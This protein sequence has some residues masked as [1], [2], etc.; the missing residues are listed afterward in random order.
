MSV[1]NQILDGTPAY[2]SVNLTINSVVYA[3]NTF[4]CT[5]DTKEAE[6]ETI[7]GYPQ[8]R[9]VVRGRYKITA[10]VQLATN[11]TTYPKFGDTFT[12]TP[13]NDSSITF[14]IDSTEQPLTNDA[15]SFN[16]IPITA[17]GAI[18]DVTTS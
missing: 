13:K 18:G 5:T 10:E 12:F 3:C 6:D 11:S 4:N 7:L 14:Y 15:G 9:R 8:R 1:P 2:G 17:T 16:T